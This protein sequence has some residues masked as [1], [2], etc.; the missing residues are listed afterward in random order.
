[1]DR[2]TI[3]GGGFSAS[4]AKILID[5]PVEV[6]SPVSVSKSP[7]KNLKA[8]LALKINKLFGKKAASFSRLRFHLL[9]AKLHD[10]LCLGGNSNIWGGFVDSSRLPSKLIQL[11]NKN[12]IFL[13]KLS[14]SDTGSIANN[15]NIHQLQHA[16]GQIYDAS[17]VLNGH[18]DFFLESLFIKDE[19][20][21][22]NLI[23]N[24]QIKTIY[25]DHLILCVGVVQLID[26]LYRSE[27]I[28]EG[29]TITLSEFSYQLK[30][31]ISFSSSSEL[32]IGST[33]IRFKL[34]R[35]VSHHLGIQKFFKVGRLFQWIPFYF[36]QLFLLKK[37]THTSQ[38][39]NGILSDCFI[40]KK[41]GS[42]IF[43]NSIH[44]CDLKI[45][46]LNI[47]EYLGRINS[48]IGGIGM[49]FVKQTIPGPISNDIMLDAIQKIEA[50]RKRTDS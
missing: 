34:F 9:L 3:V 22:L 45:N 33:L 31:K 20:V 27:L 7:N 15:K 40:E 46:G 44:Y 8:N 48:N 14:F 10:R 42:S 36:D 43:G 25:T 19:K 39:N 21:G 1:V 4:I 29:A 12:G 28:E 47:N 41:N 24:G 11:L 13:K 37:L 2:V 30:P 49:A 23:S 6:I 35:A 17:K 32:E 16:S 50:L 38:V 5:R 18:Q 26:L